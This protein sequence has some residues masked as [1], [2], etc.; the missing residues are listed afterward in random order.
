M[1]KKLATKLEERS[2]GTD[3]AFLGEL[4]CQ[5]NEAKKK[6]IGRQFAGTSAVTVNDLRSS[7][8][9]AMA[10]SAIVILTRSDG[11]CDISDEELRSIAS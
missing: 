6:L 8:E 1:N 9:D 11:E 10:Q 2:K 4:V 3:K 7:I 5:L